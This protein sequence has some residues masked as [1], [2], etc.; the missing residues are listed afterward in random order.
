MNCIRNSHK[1]LL[2]QTHFTFW[3]YPLQFHL[4][5]WSLMILLLN[6][7]LLQLR[8][9]RCILEKVVHWMHNC[10]I[11]II[12]SRGLKIKLRIAL[13]DSI[14]ILLFTKLYYIIYYVILYLYIFIL[15]YIIF[16]LLILYYIIFILFILYYITLLFTKTYI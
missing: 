7:H 11:I 3:S 16:I 2:S 10:G 12:L 5:L 9:K 14:I 6:F 13:S 8:P 15:Y 1:I 4:T